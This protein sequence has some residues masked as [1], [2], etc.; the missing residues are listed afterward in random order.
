MSSRNP[1]WQLKS[2][3]EAI[4]TNIWRKRD[5]AVD[6]CSKW[7]QYIQTFGFFGDEFQGENLYFWGQNISE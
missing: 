7:L 6:Y 5:L 3:W 2:L 4:W 1:E